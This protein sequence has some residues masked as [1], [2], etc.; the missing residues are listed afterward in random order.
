MYGLI[1]THTP[2]DPNLL[3]PEESFGR[4]NNRKAMNMDAVASFT[5]LQKK[6]DF[7]NKNWFY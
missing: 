2:F 1:Y 3:N 5:S 7:S 6:W 4:T